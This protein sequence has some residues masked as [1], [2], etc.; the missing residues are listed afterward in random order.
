MINISKSKILSIGLVLVLTVT[1]AG[2]KKTTTSSTQDST[3]SSP[4]TQT[5]ETQQSS[6][7]TIENF[8]YSPATLKA[9][10]G[11]VISVTNKDSAGH[12]VT[13]TDGKSFDTGIINKGETK[14]FIVP[15]VVGTYEYICTPH[16][17]IKGTLIVE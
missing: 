6:A 10:P 11:Q 15:A 8:A 16:P 2:C 7:I 12:T 1:L 3:Q 5:T 13:S 4:A 14:T 17:N 9:T